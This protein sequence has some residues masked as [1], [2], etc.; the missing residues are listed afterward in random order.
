MSPQPNEFDQ[1][2]RLLVCKRHEQPPPGYFHHFSDR[3]I[4]SI[5]VEQMDR[6]LTFWHWLTA[7]LETRSILACAYGAVVSGLLLMGFRLSDA[8]DGELAALPTF[9]GPG[10]FQSQPTSTS[11]F[12]MAEQPSMESSSSL[13]PS[14]RM[15]RFAEAYPVGTLRV[16]RAGFSLSH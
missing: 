13:S 6:G 7:K 14:I 1:I 4:A 15:Q 12:G 16:Q 10:D 3:V 5:E 11:L 9:S 8:F 2:R